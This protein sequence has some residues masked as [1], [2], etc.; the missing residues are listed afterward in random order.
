MVIKKILSLT[1]T[2]FIM[3]SVGITAAVATND[4]L[5]IL[6]AG[7]SIGDVNTDGDINVKDATLLQKFVAGL[8]TFS[9]N[10]KFLADANLDTEINIKDATYIQKLVAGLVKPALPTSKTEGGETLSTET[11]GTEVKTDPSETAQTETTGA[12][13]TPSTEATGSSTVP[14]DPQETTSP[15][16]HETE[17]AETISPTVATEPEETEAKT[18]PVTRDPNKPV[19]LPFVPAL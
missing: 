16:E 4:M 18:E 19:E 17:P 10:Q 5:E 8:V 11:R 7:Y 9:D 15:T 6:P 14:A 12:T 1:L 2:A 13:E 3:L